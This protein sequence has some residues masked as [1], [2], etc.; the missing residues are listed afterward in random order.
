VR[1]HQQYRAIVV[2]K[3]VLIGGVKKHASSWFNSKKE[4]LDWVWAIRTGN[5]SSGRK[6]LAVWLEQ[7]S[8]SGGPTSVSILY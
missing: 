4:M 5:E 7:R 1:R 8:S 2:G 3:T 6:I